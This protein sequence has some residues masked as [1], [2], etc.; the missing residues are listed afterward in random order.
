[1]AYQ[2]LFDPNKQFQNVA[3]TNN[4]AGF[5]RVF[6]NGTDDRAVTYKDFNGTANPADIPIDNN[7]RAVVIVNE[8]MVYRLEVYNRDGALLWSQYPL[9]PMGGGG[10]SSISGSTFVAYYHTTPYTEIKAAIDNGYNVV[11][12]MGTSPFLSVSSIDS[13]S[14]C[15]S[16]LFKN[17]IESTPLSS[18]ASVTSSDEWEYSTIPIFY[19]TDNSIYFDKSTGYTKTQ[20]QST[21]VKSYNGNSYEYFKVAHLDIDMPRI[22]EEHRVS[23]KVLF[24]IQA[25]NGG[26]SKQGCY[27][28]ELDLH[29]YGYKQGEGQEWNNRR[30]AHGSLNYDWRP[31]NMTKVD[32]VIVTCT[33]L[34]SNSK[35]RYEIW[36]H[37]NRNYDEII[38]A[39]ALINE[40]YIFKTTNYSTIGYTR[41][42]WFFEGLVDYYSTIRPTLGYSEVSTINVSSK[43]DSA[44][45]ENSTNAVQNATLYSIIQSLEARIAALG[46]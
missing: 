41:Q 10:G 15:F 20:V 25:I 46:G 43:Y 12:K 4:V 21:I 3:G 35:W 28:Q 6:Y 26:S 36:A 9:V 19:P 5:L 22:L 13:S 30:Y 24:E 11:L 14:I 44:L 40:L 34:E 31:G 42:P 37:V 38:V 32:S 45:D 33:Y 8:D 16:S 18:F 23:L 2:Y 1:M 39:K 29:V 17:Q 7:G 27:T